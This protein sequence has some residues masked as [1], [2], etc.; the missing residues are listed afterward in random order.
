MTNDRLVLYFQ[1]TNYDDFYRQIFIIYNSSKNKYMIY[2]KPKDQAEFSYSVNSEDS[3]ILL[4]QNM[5]KNYFI[6]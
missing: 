1:E 6:V 4:L 2:G 5:F 3:V